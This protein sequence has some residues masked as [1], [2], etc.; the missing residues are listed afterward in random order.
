MPDFI[1]P[2][3]PIVPGGPGDNA[4][5]GIDNLVDEFLRRRTPPPTPAP[6]SEPASPPSA[7]P[8]PPPLPLPEQIAQPLPTLPD[9]TS[10]ASLALL[11]QATRPNRRP[12][13]K[14]DA[15][16]LERSFEQAYGFSGLN[17][18]RA[19]RMARKR[20]TMRAQNDVF[21][22]IDPRSLPVPVGQAMTPGEMQDAIDNEARQRATDEDVR[23]RA[24]ERGATNVPNRAP[25]TRRPR[26]GRT[27]RGVGV[28]VGVGVEQGIE[29]IG[30]GLGGVIGERIYG[31]T[32]AEDAEARRQEREL[33]E[34]MR[35]ETAP[36]PD[37]ILV[38]GL[39]SGEVKFPTPPKLPGIDYKIVGGVAV[40]KFPTPKPAPAAP[41]PQRRNR[42]QR[43]LSKISSVTRNPWGQLGVFGLGLLGGR[44]RSRSQLLPIDVIEPEPIDVI[45][46]LT[47]INAGA[48]PFAPY[49]GFSGGGFAAQSTSCDCKPKRRGPKRRCLERADVSWRTGRYKGKRAGSKCVRWE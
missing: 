17:M 18:R 41:P 22:P 45:E 48:L 42:V 1:F 29:S 3:L 38:G 26:V 25:P 19:K 20:R 15:E 30:T 11:A 24:R 23:R 2:F 47:P 37:E 5:P 43:A 36:F 7:D 32:A 6:P 16:A 10:Y 35:R 39:P 40:R 46:P 9:A 44:K 12:R 14:G 8:A 49:A 33:E 21:T 31:R 13:L 34:R 28:G 4:Y 27:A